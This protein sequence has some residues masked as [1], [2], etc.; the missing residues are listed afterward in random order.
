VSTLESEL[1]H[2]LGEF[3]DRWRRIKPTELRQLWDPAET[4]PFYIAE[5][6]VNPMYGWDAIEPYWREAETILLK[7][8]VRTWDLKC[9]LLSDDIAAMNF[10]MHWD[11]L[12]K[13]ME[14]APLGLDVRVSAMVR[15][16]AEGWRF[17]HWVESPLGALPYLK[18]VYTRNVDPEFTK[19]L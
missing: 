2:L 15:K 14:D 12:V 17:C 7:F 13:G 4:E 3:C 5:E 6:I 18:T 19:S 11:G 16:T 9:K 1:E 8:A 10:M